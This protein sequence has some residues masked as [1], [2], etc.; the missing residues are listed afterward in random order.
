MRPPATAK[1]R[2]RLHCVG[3]PSAAYAAQA[4]GEARMRSTLS[5]FRVEVAGR[6]SSGE[7]S[8]TL[9]AGGNTISDETRTVAFAVVEYYS[10][11]TST[12]K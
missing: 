4:E 11:S 5:A 7:A 8:V 2:P 10:N 12:T 9:S 1:A 6:K 3:P